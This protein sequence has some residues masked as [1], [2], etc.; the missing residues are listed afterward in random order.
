MGLTTKGSIGAHTALRIEDCPKVIQEIADS[1]KA[2][3]KD[4]IVLCHG[5]PIS[6]P[7]DA[8]YILQHT[9]GV[10]GFFGASSIERL[11]TEGAI[12]EQ[13][14]RFKSIRFAPEGGRARPAPA[15][16]RTRNPSKNSRSRDSRNRKLR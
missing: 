4:V 12:T 1:A 15:I 6:E 14:R 3:R 9:R 2:V 13:A 7:S 16:A 8:E 5:G 11:A 10:D